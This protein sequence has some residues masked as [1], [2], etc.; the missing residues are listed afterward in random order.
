MYDNA[1]GLHT[2][3]LNRDPN[4][5][6]IT[7][8]LVDRFHWSNHKGKSVH[9]YQCILC[10]Y[11][12]FIGCSRAYNIDYYP[13]LNHLNTEV[14][15]QANSSISMLKSQLS[16]MNKRNFFNHLKLFLWYRNQAKLN[17]M[18]NM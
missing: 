9:C 3:C 10:M 11:H 14:N 1:C 5:F 2:Y 13:S 7:K 18:H 4:F 17:N 15:E 6:K 8:F 12:D 16:Y